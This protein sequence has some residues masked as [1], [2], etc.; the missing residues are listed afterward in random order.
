MTQNDKEGKQLFFSSPFI[1]FPF[2]Q[3]GLPHTSSL[4]LSYA[5]VSKW[6]TPLQPYTSLGISDVGR[7]YIGLLQKLNV[8][9]DE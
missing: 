6:C 8:T 4:T 9:K 5:H 1:S 7:T 2:L 3:M